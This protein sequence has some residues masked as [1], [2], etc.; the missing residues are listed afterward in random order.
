MTLQIQ[1]TAPADKNTW[2]ALWKAYLAFYEAELS[3]DIYQSTFERYS[4]PEVENMVSWIAWLDDQP[5]GLANTIIHPDGWRLEPVT[6]LQDLYVSP[7]ARC[8][9]VARAL[10]ENIYK[11]ADEQN[12]AS[13]YWL[14]QENNHTAQTLY[15]RIA[16]KS[17]FLVYERE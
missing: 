13:V 11:D 14:T 17:D 10:I 7:I 6:Y 1:P 15:D 8:K 5:V 16:K 2:Y 12:R 3:D 9:G 4:D